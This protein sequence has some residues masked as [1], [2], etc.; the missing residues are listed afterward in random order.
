MDLERKKS[1]EFS[2][3]LARGIRVLEIF[4]PDRKFVTTSE[5]AEII[6]ISRAASRRLLL[7]LTSL[8]YLEQTKSDFG[9]T[10][11]ISS[12]GQ[13]LLARQDQWLQATSM[14][15]ELSSKMNESFAISVLEGNRAKYVARDQKKRISS[16]PLRV[17]DSLPSHCSAAGKVLLSGLSSG[18][19]DSLLEGQSLE[20]CTEYSIIDIVELKECL[21]KVRL[22]NWGMAED[23]FELGMIAIAVPVFDRKGKVISSLSVG[24]SKQRRTVSELKEEFLPVLQDAAEKLSSVM[25]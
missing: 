5:V 18:E 2:L 12:I 17:G 10:G 21:R 14:V 1:N 7:T 3:T 19:L 23:E 11:K 24:S 9:L 16:M 8:G 6:G 13:G 25:N 22:Q 4:S 20:K 15:L